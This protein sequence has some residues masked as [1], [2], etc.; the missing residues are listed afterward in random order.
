MRDTSSLQLFRGFE[1][2]YR[3]KGDNILRAVYQ[4]DENGD[5]RRYLGVERRIRF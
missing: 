5:S 1:I 3:I 4:P 2:I